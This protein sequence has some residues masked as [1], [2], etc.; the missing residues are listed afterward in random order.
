MTQNRKNFTGLGLVFGAGIGII[1]S[2]IFTLNIGLSVAL[3]G[4]V[5]LI[6]GSIISMNKK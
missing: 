2:L 5:G 3:G 4:G 6:I 1:I